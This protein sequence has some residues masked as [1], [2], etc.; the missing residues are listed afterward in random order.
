MNLENYKCGLDL[1]K[2]SYNLN[3]KIIEFL[4]IMK[5]Q[6]I[7]KEKDFSRITLYSLINKK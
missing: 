6:N 1:N 3:D 5:E 2:K 4:K 7:F